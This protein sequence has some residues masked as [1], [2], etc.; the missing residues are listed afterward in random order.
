[1]TE[2]SHKVI[3][4]VLTSFSKHLS[5]RKWRKPHLWYA[6]SQCVYAFLCVFTCV[7]TFLWRCED[8]T[9]YPPS[10]LSTLL[11]KTG[12][13]TE[14]TNLVQQFAYELQRSP[15]FHLFR[16]GITGVCGA[17]LFMWV[18]RIQIRVFMLILHIPAY[19]LC[20][21]TSPRNI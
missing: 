9:G 16:A 3:K 19:Q 2:E 1:M 20:H 14:P 12:S 7:Y 4:R 18:Q 5:Q 17:C 8:A 11:F 15:S 10:L 6:C 13:F 21:L